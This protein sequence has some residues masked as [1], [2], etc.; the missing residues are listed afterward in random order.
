[1]YHNGKVIIIISV[2]IVTGFQEPLPFQWFF[3]QKVYQGHMWSF[4]VQQVWGSSTKFVSGHLHLRNSPGHDIEDLQGPTFKIINIKSIIKSYEYQYS[5]PRLPGKMSGISH[6]SKHMEIKIMS[7]KNWIL[8]VFIVIYQDETFCL[9]PVHVTAENACT[10]IVYE[11][12][13]YWYYMN[14]LR[15]GP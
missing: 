5:Q 12:I 4:Q 7:K 3:W 9:V 6:T 2:Y 11:Y 10:C 14:Y 1:M 8:S 13:Y 15:S